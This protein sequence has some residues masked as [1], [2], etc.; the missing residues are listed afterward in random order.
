MGWTLSTILMYIP[1]SSNTWE[2]W[3]NS[4]LNKSEAITLST[5]FENTTCQDMRHETE[6]HH[7]GI[8][9]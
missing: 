3:W 7:N 6:T 2:K 8:A 5:S 9:F 1:G 4:D